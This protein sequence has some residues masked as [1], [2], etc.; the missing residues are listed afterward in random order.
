KG[1][2][3]EYVYLARPDT[4]IAG[5]SVHL[6]R[7]EVGRRLAQEHPAEADLV[8][9]VPE[10][11]TPAA[12]GYAEQ[13]GLPYGMGLVKN[14]YVGRTSIQPSQTLR[15][16]GIRLKLNP[17]RE[18]VDDTR[19]VVVGDSIVRGN[20]PP[21]RAS[22]PPQAG[23]RWAPVRSSRPRSPS[24]ARPSTST[25]GPRAPGPS[26]APPRSSPCASTASCATWTPSWPT[27]RPSRASTSPAPTGSRSCATAPPT[28]SPRPCR[29]RTPT[30]SA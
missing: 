19:L 8:I 6:T 25:R 28:C 29:G 27:G 11:G 20:T 23:A 16:L 2:L 1:C 30:R 21:P 7:V 10:S 24:T 15:Q 26:R 5:R 3:F 14:S 9:P 12:V 18:V 4:R 17:L 22:R 13:S